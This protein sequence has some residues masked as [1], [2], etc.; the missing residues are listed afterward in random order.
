MTFQWVL[1]GSL[2]PVPLSS[3]QFNLLPSKP[4]CSQPSILKEGFIAFL[5]WGRNS[6]NP[7]EALSWVSHMEDHGKVL[8][9]EAKQRTQNPVLLNLGLTPTRSFMPHCLPLPALLQQDGQIVGSWSLGSVSTLC[10]S[11]A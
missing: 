8:I 5:L 6:L 1:L 2:T 10:L 9:L 11:W 4:G 7:P 3:S